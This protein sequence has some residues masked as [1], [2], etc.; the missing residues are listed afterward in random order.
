MHGKSVPITSKP[1]CTVTSN[2]A[3][4]KKVLKH[5]PDKRR[6]RGLAVKEGDDDYF[7]C[8]TRGKWF[9]TL[10]PIMATRYD[11][12]MP[13]GSLI[14]LTNSCVLL[15]SAIIP[16]G[17]PIHYLDQ[18]WHVISWVLLHSPE[19]SFKIQSKSTE[20]LSYDPQKLFV[21]AVVS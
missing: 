11:L 4:K 12:V 1:V 9:C 20:I 21:N 5:H 10:C 14:C 17:T 3:D 16:R 18:W 6:A 8:I 19:V 2:I 7:T 15:V 13:Y